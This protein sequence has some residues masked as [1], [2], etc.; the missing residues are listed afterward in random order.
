[1]T[2]RC[3][4]K[5]CNRTFNT[6][7]NSRIFD[8]EKGHGYICPY[9]YHFVDANKWSWRPEPRSKPHGSKKERRRQREIV[10]HG[11]GLIDPK[12]LK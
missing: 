1:M 5:E 11:R 4:R 10:L 3:P 9:C 6:D 7:Y 2:I 8:K 12:D